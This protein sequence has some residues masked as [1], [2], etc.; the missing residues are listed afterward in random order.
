MH[1][2]LPLVKH[3]CILYIILIYRSYLDEEILIC[4]S[5]CGQEAVMS[6]L[7]IHLIQNGM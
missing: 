7:K 2:Q 6:K 3:L 5:V 4:V 1:I